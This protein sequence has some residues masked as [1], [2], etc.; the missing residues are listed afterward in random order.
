MASGAHLS[1]YLVRFN[2]LASRVEWGDAVLHFQF[3]D[4]LPDRLKDRITLLGKPNTLQEL[5]QVTI[6]HD[7][8]Y[9]EHQD[10]HKQV[11]Q[12]QPPQNTTTRQPW[13]DQP[14]DCPNE[15]HIARGR[16]KD[17]E[18]C[19]CHENNLCLYCRKSDH[20]IAKCPATMKGQVAVLPSETTM[21]MLTPEPTEPTEPSQLN[22]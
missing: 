2:T 16:I 1:E 11:R 9:W 13:S 15:Q 12:Q 10:E 4:S 14:S 21:E 22:E 3:Y 5:V 7:N 17:E 8:L 18:Q 6:H 19:Q 20:T